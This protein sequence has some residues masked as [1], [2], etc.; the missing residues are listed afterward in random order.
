MTYAPRL[1]AVLGALAILVAACGAT[2]A[3]PTLDGRTFVSTGVDGHVLVP[4]T[5]IVLTFRNGTDLGASAGCNTIGG[6]YTLANGVLRVQAGGMTEMG[7]DPDRH[8]QDD[9]LIDFL[10]SEPR[11]TLLGNDLTLAKDGTTI[12]LLDREIAQPD[13]PLIGPVWTL[14]SLIQ[15]DAVASVPGGVRATLTFTPD[16]QVQVDAG[17]NTGGGTAGVQGDRITF[18]PIGTTKRAC[19]APAAAVESAVLGVLGQGQVTFAIDASRLT[20]VAPNGTG[21]GFTTG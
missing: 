13:Q 16:G 5:Q 15:G 9:W 1:A 19:E 8:A 12:R 11:I 20:I 4:G 18:G 10:T 2:P 6:T 3:P 14:D 7:C 17:C 21:L